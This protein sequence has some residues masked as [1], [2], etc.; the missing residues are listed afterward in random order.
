MDNDQ[1]NLSTFSNVVQF[2]RHHTVVFFSL[3]FAVLISFL[4]LLAYQ[5][6]NYRD[7]DAKALQKSFRD[8]SAEIGNNFLGVQ[9]RM[10]AEKTAAEYDLF[11][12]RFAPQ[13]MPLPYRF[14]KETPTRDF[15]HLDQIDDRFKKEINGNLSGK[16][17]LIRKDDPDFARKMR[18]YLNLIGG[19]KGLKQ[20]IPNLKF[21]YMI[22][23]DKVFLQ[24]PWLPTSES[25]FEEQLYDYDVWKLGL[26]K[27][28]SE[29]KPY[30]TDAYID[31]YGCGL[32]T[33]CGAPIYDQDKFIGIIAA[34]IAVDYL[35]DVV[36]K[37]EPERRG[38]AIIFDRGRNILAHPGLTSGKDKKVKKLQDGLPAALVSDLSSIIAAPDGIIQRNGNWRYLK[39]GLPGS[40]FQ[41]LYF[42]P[43]QSIQSWA[44]ERIGF[45]TIC[46][47]I[48]LFLLLSIFMSIIHRNIVSPAEKFVNFILAH[49]RGFD[50]P[51]DTRLPLI[52]KPWFAEVGKVFTR[53]KQL[54]GDLRTQNIELEQK[55][56]M[57]NQEIEARTRS[58]QERL[59][60]ERQLMQE[61]KI[62]AIGMLAGGVAHDFNNQ[63]GIIVG[64][65][66]VLLSTKPISDAQRQDC[67]EQILAAAT[68]SSDLTRQLL[69]FAR[70]GD[71][72]QNPMDIHDLI[73]EVISICNHTMDKRVT[74]KTE[75]NAKLYTVNGDQ[76]QI[77]NVLMN[78]VIN[79]Q[80]A[81]PN[82]GMVTIKT[83]NRILTSEDC[84]GSNDAMTPGSHIEIIISDTGI[85]MDAETRERV[86]E[87]FFTTRNS[88][89]GTGL[90]LAAAL[91]SVKNHQGNITVDSAVDV[92][93]AFAVTLP[94]M[95]ENVAVKKN[96]RNHCI[97]VAESNAKILLVDDESAFCRMITDFMGANGYTVMAFSDP[98]DAIACYRKN[99]QDID[100]VIMDIMMP[101]LSGYDFFEELMSINSE[102]K[103]VISSGYST[104]EKTKSLLHNTANVIALFNKP[105]N[106]V[107][108]VNEVGELLKQIKSPVP[109]EKT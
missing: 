64:Y 69:A 45:E 89:R 99:W 107:Q 76:S 86:F 84:S 31:C 77:R 85:G 30:W 108:F 59:S 105:F 7:L 46:T 12:T 56:V 42:F 32:M 73:L 14:I 13:N 62:K 49:S 95:G 101:K 67:L 5:Y 2:E 51:I 19:F 11:E 93:S 92:G 74:F 71:F 24:F 103:V 109:A 6:A 82:G 72:Q 97:K 70:K 65:T 50:I 47:V 63:L 90:G 21:L 91:G 75:L 66:S 81:M 98:F 38:T 26:P 48:C 104:E 9:S 27:G 102:V 25:K 79:A 87:P 83:A 57:L 8:F 3:F 29:R 1:K 41:L 44:M 55:N 16:G 34:D 36:K 4:V 53:N 39:I 35:N 54:T 20:S 96:I 17:P 52:W 68:S 43:E 28:N 61:E 22:S 23:A 40:P 80:H 33:S 15:F 100:L 94:V 60:L 78:I 18:M 88:G 37:F 10:N 106:L 58:E